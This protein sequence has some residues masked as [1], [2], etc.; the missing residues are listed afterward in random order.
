MSMFN[1]FKTAY[2]LFVH[3]WFH[4]V[5]TS[6]SRPPSLLHYA[7]L[8]VA[9]TMLGLPI[10]MYLPV[11]YHEHYGLALTTIGIVLFVARSLDV[12]TDI[13]LG[14]LSDKWVNHVDR[15]WLVI[16]GLV[17][18]AAASYFLFFPS[19][20][21]SWQLFFSVSALYVFWTVAQVNYLA[22]SAEYGL[23]QMQLTRLHGSRESAGLMGILLVLIVPYVLALQPNQIEFYDWFWL[24]LL[25]CLVIGGGLLLR[26]PRSC[27]EPLKEGQAEEG[28]STTVSH[29]S[30]SVSFVQILGYVREHK[31]VFHLMPAYFLNNLA[32]AIPATLFIVFVSDYMQLE[33]QM[34]LL[35]LVYFVAGL[36]ALPLWLKLSKFLGNYRCWQVS[37][38]L[39]SI[40]FCGVFWLH[41]GQLEWY[42]WICILTGLSV[43]IDLTLPT[44]IQTAL[45]QSLPKKEQ[46]P[47]I[48][49]GV[50]GL[51]TK[52]SLA[53]AVLIALPVFEWGMT[54]QNPDILLWLYAAPAIVLKM[55]A[56]FLL[57]KAKP[58]RT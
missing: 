52:L 12:F 57:S 35:L 29:S 2:F 11:L 50:W 37:M 5:R 39:A 31:S 51:L 42:L 46:Q 53:M 45:I 7:S 8:S 1:P 40:S 54:Q 19:H 25:I 55:I 22:I 3:A 49:F 33:A 30:S 32:N 16:A 47:G 48:V 34:G 13:W 10:Y 15:I 58:A 36:L 21:S 24:T 18:I 38:L 4:R 23:S 9:L 26:L 28:L 41:P 43:V 56:I 27:P 17:G 6:D 20:A 44:S 14:Q